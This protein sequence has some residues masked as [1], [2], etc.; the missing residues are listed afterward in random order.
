MK[1]C[2]SIIIILLFLSSCAQLNKDRVSIVIRSNPPN[3]HLYINNAYYGQT[4]QK[5]SLIPDSDINYKAT[6]VGDNYSYQKTIPLET[7]SSLRGYRGWETARCFLDAVGSMLVFP[8]VSFLSVKCRDF[9]QQEY[10]IN[11]YRQE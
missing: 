8:I 3:S 11:A 6:I 7:W 10:L 9:K 2:P 4:P 5:I 1:N